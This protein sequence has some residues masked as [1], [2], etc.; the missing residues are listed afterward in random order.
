MSDFWARK[1]GAPPQPRQEP[2]GAA[3]RPWWDIPSGHGQQQPPDPHPQP[4]T[5]PQAV[6]AP[7]HQ[8][9]AQATLK[10]PSARQNGHCPNCAGTNY[11]S[12]P[13]LPNIAARCYECGYPKLHTTSGSGIPTGGQGPA[14]PSRQV[15]T[16]NN[17]NPGV[18]VGH[19]G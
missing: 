17:Y 14:T 8:R 7:E 2:V 5:H 6:P 19:I 4:D 12:P 11:F 15:S 1:L 18:I 3:P 9:L 16:A 13:G 10:A